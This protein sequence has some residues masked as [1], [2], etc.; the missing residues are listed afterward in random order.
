MCMKNYIFVK[1]LQDQTIFTDDFFYFAI[2]LHHAQPA[3]AEIPDE[4]NLQIKWIKIRESNPLCI[5][6][7]VYHCFCVLKVGLFKNGRVSEAVNTDLFSY[8]NK[9][10][11]LKKAY[12]CKEKT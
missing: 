5:I 10:S 2:L 8:T 1:K 11:S 3:N 6:L 9:L 4:P 12:N 7:I